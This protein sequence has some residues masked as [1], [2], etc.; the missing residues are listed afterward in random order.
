MILSNIYI[1]NFYFLQKNFEHLNRHGRLVGLPMVI[2]LDV[3]S[4]SPNGYPCRRRRL[5]GLPMVI[6]VDVDA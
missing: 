6:P 4:R 1:L 5:V 3:T 2:P